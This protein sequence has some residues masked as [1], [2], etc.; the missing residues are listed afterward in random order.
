MSIFNGPAGKITDV[1]ARK[2]VSDDIA[3]AKN[4]IVLLF[5]NTAELIWA[6]NKEGYYLY[7][8]NAYRDAVSSE[9][10]IT[11]EQGDAIDLNN[12]FPAAQIEEWQIF[13]NRAFKGERFTVRTENM[14]N[15][16]GQSV[17]FE[18]SF[19]PLYKS[20]EKVTGIGC[21][22]RN[23]TELVNTEKAIIDQNE[24]LRHIASISSHEL[25]RPVAS[26]LGLMNIIDRENFENPDNK[27]IIEHLLTVGKEIDDVIRLIIN[28]TFANDPLDKKYQNP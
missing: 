13:Y 15:T 5:N 3:W 6:I 7:T 21:F 25:R 20:K 22:A 8:N 18:V 1:A 17:Y 12:V 26:L 28:K 24:R 23:I 11:P 27:E 9:T 19:N 10:G 16:T 14:D 2:A 4:N